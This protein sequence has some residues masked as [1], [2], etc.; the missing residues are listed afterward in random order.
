MT[1]RDLLL[2]A[3]VLVPKSIILTFE[4]PDEYI[5]AV[6]VSMVYSFPLGIIKP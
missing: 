3:R 2:P 1:F 5:F 4:R 6:Q